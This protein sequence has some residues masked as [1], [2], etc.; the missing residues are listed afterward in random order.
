MREVLVLPAEAEEA[1]RRGQSGIHTFSLSKVLTREQA[2]ALRTQLAGERQFQ[3]E[4]Y[5]IRKIF[6]PCES[7]PGVKVTLFYLEGRDDLPGIRRV[8]LQIEPCAVMGE[9]NPFALYHPTKERHRAFT[10]RLEY[11]LKEL[12]VPGDLPSLSLCRVDVTANLPLQSQVELEETLRIVK[13]S[14][15]PR[16]YRYVTFDP[17]KRK[18]KEPQRAN[19]RSHCIGNRKARFLIYDKTDQLRMTG[20][21]LLDHG[22]RPVLR[23][24]VQL[25]REAFQRY[26]PQE[27]TDLRACLKQLYR[28]RKEILQHYLQAMQ[29]DLGHH[30]RYEAAR[31]VI[32]TR[33]KEGNVQTRMLLLLQKCSDCK[34]WNAMEEKLRKGSGWSK[35]QWENTWK[36]YRELSLSPITLPNQ[37]KIEEIMPLGKRLEV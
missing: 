15:L 1:M 31:Q 26:L 19:E 28:R 23:L 29:L 35:K 7:I 30:L 20:R 10:R 12:G 18:A 8:S 27:E 32:R 17:R 13:K 6:F 33:V 2:C 9:E 24:E 34:T 14:K 5:G 21:G 4:I 36:K 3:T 16:G 25:R 11:I 37:S 22:N